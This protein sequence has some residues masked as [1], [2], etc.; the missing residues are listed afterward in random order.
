MLATASMTWINNGGCVESAQSV[1]CPTQLGP[2]GESIDFRVSIRHV[3]FTSGSCIKGQVKSYPNIV[4]HEGVLVDAILY[5][6]EPLA[7][8]W[9]MGPPQAHTHVVSVRHRVG[10]WQ[11][12]ELPTLFCP[13]QTGSSSAQCLLA[14]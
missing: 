4:V 9:A 6:E 11:E 5:S 14:H 8:A 13:Y 10:F 12:P 1:C 7:V 2:G 3:G